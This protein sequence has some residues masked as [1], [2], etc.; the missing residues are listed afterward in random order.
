MANHAEVGGD[1]EHR[2]Y[3]IPGPR[4]DA[5]CLM[6][7]EHYL[8]VDAVCWFV[9]KESGW[10]ADRAAPTPTRTAAN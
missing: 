7:Q 3:L 4:T 8:S 9:N 6:A 5:G 2:A 10:F 1:G